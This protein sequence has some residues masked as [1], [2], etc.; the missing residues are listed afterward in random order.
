MAGHEA[1]VN[2]LQDLHRRKSSAASAAP[3]PAD[4]S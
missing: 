2:A 1:E 3:A 4:H